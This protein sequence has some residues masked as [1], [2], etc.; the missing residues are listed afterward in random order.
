MG[1]TLAGQKKYQEAEAF[2]LE[3]YEGMATRKDRIPVPDWYHLE[4]ARDWIIRLYSDWG[5]PEKAADWQQRAHAQEACAA[6]R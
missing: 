4:R 5:K 2:L 3:G 6:Q 1:E